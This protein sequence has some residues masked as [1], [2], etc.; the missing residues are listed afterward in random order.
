MTAVTADDQQL[1]KDIV[2]DILEV[3]PDEVTDTSIFTEEHDAD[4]M[5]LIEILSALELRL[6]VTIDQEQMARMIN[7]EGIYQVIAEIKQ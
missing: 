5:R 2:C 6:N 1:I 4:S 7:L 3:E